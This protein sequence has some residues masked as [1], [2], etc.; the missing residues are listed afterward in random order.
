[1]IGTAVMATRGVLPGFFTELAL[2]SDVKLRLPLA[3]AE[4]LCLLNAGFGK[5]PHGEVRWE[6][7][8]CVCICGTVYV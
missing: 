6:G 7:G 3:P 2:K 8:L 5:S 4:G 1:M